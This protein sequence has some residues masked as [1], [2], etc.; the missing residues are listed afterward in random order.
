VVKHFA[1]LK[2]P[3]QF[4]IRSFD[5]S[6]ICEWTFP[7]LDFTKRSLFRS[8]TGRSILYISG[9]ALAVMQITTR[10]EHPVAVVALERVQARLK[11]LVDLGSP[12]RGKPAIRI[13]GAGRHGDDFYET[14]FR[15]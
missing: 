3:V 12:T 4:D 13:R 9:E 10:A 8:L 1:S 2:E 5:N 14:A 11:P 6:A 7:G 15:R